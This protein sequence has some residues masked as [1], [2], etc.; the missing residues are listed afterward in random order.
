M[1]RDIYRASNG[2]FTV[3]GRKGLSFTEAVEAVLAL[4]SEPRRYL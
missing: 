3:D 1:G 2:L 4:K